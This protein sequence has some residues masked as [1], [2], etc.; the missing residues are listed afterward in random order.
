MDIYMLDAEHIHVMLH[1]ALQFAA[2][3]RGIMIWTHETPAPGNAI[4]EDNGYHYRMLRAETASIIGQLLVNENAA[5][6]NTQ[7]EAI[8]GYAYEYADPAHTGWNAVEILRAIEGYELQASPS[9]T[10]STSDARAL[11][12]ELRRLAVMQL[13]GAFDVPTEIYDGDMPRHVELEQP[14]LVA[15]P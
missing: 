1:T 4:E 12:D 3:R 14:E 10:W 13:P 15:M 9:P 11:C 7:P 6:V 2:P 8:G 5:A